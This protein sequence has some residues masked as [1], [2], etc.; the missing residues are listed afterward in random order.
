MRVFTQHLQWTW[1]NATL[2]LIFK[3]V[4]TEFTMTFTFLRRVRKTYGFII[5]VCFLLA[6]NVSNYVALITG[7]H[8]K[9][10]EAHMKRR[11]FDAPIVI[12]NGNNINCTTQG[13]GV[14]IE[15]RTNRL[16]HDCL[17]SKITSK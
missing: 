5:V 14:V 6:E 16:Q 2:T 7:T 11:A 13:G 8:F 10:A 15:D 4:S 17:S 12:P 3:P 1:D 9:F